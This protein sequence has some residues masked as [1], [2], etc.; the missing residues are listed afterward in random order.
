MFSSKLFAF[1]I[2]LIFKQDGEQNAHHKSEGGKHIPCIRPASH[3]FVEVCLAEGEVVDHSLGAERTDGGTQAVSHHHEHALG[4][5]ADLL[6]GVLVD[7]ERAAD[8]EEVEGYAVDDH[9]EDEEHEA[10]ARRTTCTK[11][12]ETQSPSAKGDEHHFLYTKFL[13]EEGNE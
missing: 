7:E 3:E 2:V 4:T 12:E 8:V 5:A 11:E 6:V 1:R 10:E 9:R 13:K